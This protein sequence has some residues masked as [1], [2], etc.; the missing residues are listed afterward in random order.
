MISASTAAAPT[1]SSGATLS[2]TVVGA[3]EPLVAFWPRS[4]HRHVASTRIRCLLV[5]EGLQALGWRTSLH[6]PDGPAPDVLILGKRYDDA[7][8]QQALE[9]RKQHG[10]RLLLDLCDNHFYCETPE[11]TWIERA[12]R[13][14]RACNAMDA[15]VTASESLAEVVHAECPGVHDIMVGEDPLDAWN[16]PT[17]GLTVAEQ[18]HRLRLQW[19][20]R[21]GRATPGRR[22]I[23]FGNHGADYAQGG[24]GELAHIADELTAH[25]QAAPISLVVVSNRWARYREVHRPW[26]FPSLYVPWSEAL[27]SH[28]LT[29]CD[30]ALIPSRQNPFTR[31]KTNNR[32][33]TAFLHGVAVAASGLPSYGPF[34]GQAILDDW[35]SG[36][37][38][39][40]AA[41]ADRLQRVQT[42]QDHLK[43]AFSLSCIAR[44]WERVLQAVT[45]SHPS[46][47][48]DV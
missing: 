5:M 3:S 28:A 26:P 7:S 12:E 25:H 14:R 1:L 30:I 16:V 22:L 31:C 44:K 38:S 36:L 48:S 24:M 13:L 29:H 4:P 6:N 41:H 9:L 43:R 23:W 15:V 47:R 20:H 11:P 45:A 10:T 2:G 21:Q 35:T 40:M 42:A 32:L 17:R 37:G 46:S 19:F 8:L 18:F 39:L 34:R 33:A 27:L